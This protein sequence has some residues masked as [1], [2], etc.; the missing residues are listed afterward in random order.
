MRPSN[1]ID[2]TAHKI[3]NIYL[4][5]VELPRL[6]KFVRGIFQWF[7]IWTL[8]ELFFQLFAS[9]FF[10]SQCQVSQWNVYDITRQNL[11]MI[12]TRQCM[13]N[14][15]KWYSYNRGKKH[16]L[17]KKRTCV[18]LLISCHIDRRSWLIRMAKTTT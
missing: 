8:E 7:F 6:C 18:Y 5:P 15:W 10:I 14:Q 1:A 13:Y 9:Y 12:E 4:N 17:E 3:T 16:T 2:Y 11:R